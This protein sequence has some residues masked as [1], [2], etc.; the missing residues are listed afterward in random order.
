[1]SGEWKS[2]KAMKNYQVIIPMIIIILAVLLRLVPHPANVA[3][4]A[5][6]ALFG[7]V[8]LD[9]KYVFLPLL[10]MFISD[11]FLGFHASMPMVYASFVL[12]GL[13]GLWLKTH[14]TVPLVLSAS[15]ASSLIFFLLT[16]FNYWYATPLYPKTFEGLFQSY[17]MALP[18][19]R[20]SLF[21]DLFYTGLFFG[22]YALAL[23]LINSKF[24]NLNTK[25]F[26]N[27]K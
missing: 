11:L 20:N 24:K 2:I 10:A 8:Y 3:P 23:R 26:Q 21:G 6:M 22:G 12:I 25:Q 27:T 14:K 13:I 17:M 18:F 1:L 15:V 4:I 7:G 19:F 9:K 16:N 5:A